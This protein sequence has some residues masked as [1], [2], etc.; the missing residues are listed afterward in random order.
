MLTCRLHSGIILGVKNVAAA[1]SAAPFA[2]VCLRLRRRIPFGNLAGIQGIQALPI[3]DRR[4]R[5]TS[6]PAG[7]RIPRRGLR[8]PVFFFTTE[9]RETP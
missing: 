5:F 1:L 7:E 8:F 2:A 6:H 3:R 4:S 9:T